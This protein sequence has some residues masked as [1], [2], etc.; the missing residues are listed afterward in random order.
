LLLNAELFFECRSFC[1]VSKK[2]K[3]QQHLKPTLWVMLLL[4]V[5]FLFITRFRESSARSEESSSSY[6]SLRNSYERMKRKNHGG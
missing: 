2:I 6:D 5:F 1:F 4:F 3:R